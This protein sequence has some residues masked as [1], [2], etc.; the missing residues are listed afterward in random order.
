MTSEK[1]GGRE[2]DSEKWILENIHIDGMDDV[3]MEDGKKTTS[4]S[5]SFNERSSSL[6]KRNVVTS[7]GPKMGRT[8]SGAKRGLMSLRFLDRA[9]TGKE[10]DGWR[11]IEKRFCVNS[12]DDRLFKDKFGACIGIFLKSLKIDL[13]W[14]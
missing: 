9:K 3:A 2:D 4:S 10:E 11:A 13:F 1:S 14:G 5:T 7:S 12:V 8:E 6:R